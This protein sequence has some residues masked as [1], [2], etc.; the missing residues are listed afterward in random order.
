M[1]AATTNRSLKLGLLDIRSK[2]ELRSHA[3]EIVQTRR[4]NI[5]R[6]LAVYEGRVPVRADRQRCREHVHGELLALLSGDALGLHIRDDPVEE[7]R[8]DGR[9]RAW[10]VGVD[11]YQG[12]FCED[13]AAETTTWVLDQEQALHIAMQ[14]IWR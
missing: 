9:S 3:R 12:V 11:H 7:V 2:V 8:Y 4:R 10:S 1:I 14:A 5:V 6:Q 13:L